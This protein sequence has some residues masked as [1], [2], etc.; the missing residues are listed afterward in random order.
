MG[1]GNAGTY[2]F[3]DE[4]KKLYCAGYNG[5]GYVGVGNTDVLS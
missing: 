4:E 3:I 1:G 2:C 5:N